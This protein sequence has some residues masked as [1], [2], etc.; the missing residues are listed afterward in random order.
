MDNTTSLGLL[1][2]SSMPQTCARTP[3]YSR[4]NCSC[5]HGIHLT[6][7]T[8]L[9]ALDEKPA[10]KTG[11][12]HD[13]TT[14]LLFFSGCCCSPA[15]AAWRCSYPS[16]PRPHCFSPAPRPMLACALCCALASRGLQPQALQ[17]GKKRAHGVRGTRKDWTLARL[18][19][20]DVQRGGRKRKT[21]LM[22]QMRLAGV[23][24][25]SLLLL[26]LLPL[27]LLLHLQPARLNWQATAT[28]SCCHQLHSLP[29][30]RQLRDEGCCCRQALLRP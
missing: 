6:R 29:T 4:T 19:T 15:A 5:I 2:I 14:P 7:A 16:H 8:S 27:P 3:I 25:R 23:T 20:A 18:A 11:K 30:P 12:H 24:E 17:L 1:C 21:R 22:A 9:P 13:N 26:P 10:A 28:D